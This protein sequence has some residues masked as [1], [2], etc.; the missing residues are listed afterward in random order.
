MWAPYSSLLYQTVPSDKAAMLR[1]GAVV[2]SYRGKVAASA[3][4]FLIEVATEPRQARLLIEST[5]TDADG[6]NTVRVVVDYRPSTGE[7]AV[8]TRRVSNSR[9]R[10]GSR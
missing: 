6:F 2:A 4:G 3:S 7:L 5:A 9:R 8:A 1:G 10:V